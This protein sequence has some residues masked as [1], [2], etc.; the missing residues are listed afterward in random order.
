MFPH[1]RQTRS[2]RR[3]RREGGL[4]G[5]TPKR[6]RETRVLPLKWMLAAVRDPR[7]TGELLE[8]GGLLGQHRGLFS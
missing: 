2:R 7:Y 4:F 1:G 3:K 6:T 5:E 8:S